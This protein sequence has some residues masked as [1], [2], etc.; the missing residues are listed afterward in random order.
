MNYLNK[1]IKAVLQILLDALIITFSS[2]FAAFAT[3]GLGDI[4][5][6]NRQLFFIYALL[7][8]AVSIVAIFFVF[9]LYYNISEYV[10]AIEG[11]K[12]ICSCLAVT[13]LHFV[14]CRYLFRLGVIATLDYA[15]IFFFVLVCLAAVPRYFGRVIQAVK[16]HIVNFAN[17]NRIP[18]MIVGAGD[19]GAMLLREIETSDKI[20]YAVK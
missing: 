14:E 4:V 5:E 1:R 10:G 19:A 17:G 16:G 7:M 2:V 11:L 15:L 8:N 6:S 18:V 3:G 9:K 12:I 20:E 13:V